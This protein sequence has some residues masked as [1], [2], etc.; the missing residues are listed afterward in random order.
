MKKTELGEF[1]ALL[2][3]M[4][5]RLRGDVN[6]LTKEALGTD[7]HDGGSESKSP[8]HMAELGSDAFE[9]EFALS[10]VAN[11]QETLT[12]ISAALQRIKDG[13]F[14]QCE[15]CLKDGKSPS[16]AAIPKARLRAI[17]YTRNCVECERIKEDR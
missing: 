13:T 12:E 6:Q 8:T 11:E 5:R 3:E 17:P 1:R 14:G 2:E 16:Q 4:Q 10:L 9:Q 7:R 15:L